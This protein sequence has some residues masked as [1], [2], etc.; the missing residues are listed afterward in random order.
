[1]KGLR[2]AKILELIKEDVYDTQEDL[3]QKLGELGFSVT[4][5]TVSR[6]IRELGIIKSEGDDGVYK[7]RVASENVAGAG[8]TAFASILRHAAIKVDCANNLVVVKTYSGMGSAAGA[9]VDA[10]ELENVIGTLAG[11]DTLLII[12]SD[13]ESASAITAKLKGLIN[14]RDK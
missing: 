14:D 11:D 10:M 6:D 7:Y 1:M 2:Q 13:N 8:T 3:Q 5:A 12:A 4:Q 9:A